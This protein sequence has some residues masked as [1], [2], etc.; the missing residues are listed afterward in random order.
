VL[1]KLNEV[2]RDFLVESLPCAFLEV[3]TAII[4]WKFE[5]IFIGG[6]IPLGMQNGS[7]VNAPVKSRSQLIEHF[8][9]FE[10]DVIHEVGTVERPEPNFP[11]SIVIHAHNNVVEVFG[12]SCLIP[13]LG[14][15]FSV[16]ICSLDSQPASFE[17]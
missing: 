2:R 16:S 6:R 10:R 7:L 12:L 14:N 15:L 9:K 5:E 1:D 3:T 13:Q 8:S 17:A 4:D 11:G